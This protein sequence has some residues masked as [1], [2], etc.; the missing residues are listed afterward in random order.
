MIKIQKK[1][2]QQQQQQQSI[3]DPIAFINMIGEHETA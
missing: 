3:D 2:N 1:Y